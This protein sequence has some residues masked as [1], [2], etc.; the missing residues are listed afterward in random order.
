MQDNKPIGGEIMPT[1]KYNEL[2]RKWSGN[3]RKI[4]L[5]NI[6]ALTSKGKGE[7]L[8]SLKKRDQSY[9]GEVR[10]VSFEFVKHG[11]FL[12]KGVGNGYIINNGS[13]VRGRRATKEETAYANAKSRT[14][15]KVTYN[16]SEINRSPV[17]W[18]DSSIDFNMNKLADIVN[19]YWGDKA[20]LIAS[21][22]KIEK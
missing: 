2:V 16:S 21:K 12:H 17:D 4:L 11:V 1:E 20:L 14:M 8:S 10:K 19:E 15:Q 3:M 13:V 18:F 7:L 5:T 22:M 9:H 6:A